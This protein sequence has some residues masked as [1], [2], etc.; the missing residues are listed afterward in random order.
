MPKPKGRKPKKR[1]YPRL[2][3]NPGVYRLYFKFGLPPSVNSIWV[4]G[5][6]GQF[7]SP[8]YRSWRTTNI[9][10]IQ[11]EDSY[12]LDSEISIEIEITAGK[13]FR[14]NSDI[15]NRVKGI[16]DLLVFGGVIADD[17]ARHLTSIYV[18][19]VNKDFKNKSLAY[20]EVAVTGTSNGYIRGTDVPG[21]SRRKRKTDMG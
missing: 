13:G 2:E 15:D 9:K 16:L 12:Q 8:G 17:S 5:R 14:A 7:L 10:H 6:Y 18:R 20:A 21:K 3:H 19:L 1:A 11:P 4:R